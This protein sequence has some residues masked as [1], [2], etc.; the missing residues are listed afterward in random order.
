MDLLKIFTPSFLGNVVESIIMCNA[1]IWG[2]HE[3]K[4]ILNIQTDALR[5]LLGVG[6][7]C[8]KAGL[9]RET[10]R[11]PFKISIKFS[12]LRFKKRIARL[13]VD[14]LTRKIYLWSDLFSG[15]ITNWT[16]KTKQLM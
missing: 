1:C 13:D 2:H 9:H 4:N 6:K 7:A 15:T 5:F 16:W 14:R 3:N 11:V 8:S 12:I 10:G